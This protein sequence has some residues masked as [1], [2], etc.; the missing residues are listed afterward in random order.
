MPVWGGKTPITGPLP[1]TLSRVAYSA[2]STWALVHA[3]QPCRDGLAEEGAPPPGTAVL[4]ALQRQ[5]GTWAVSRAVLLY[6]E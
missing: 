6:V 2:D 4:A 3:A 1:I 5:R